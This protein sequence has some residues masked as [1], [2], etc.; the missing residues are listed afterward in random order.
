[1][2]IFTFLWKRPNF[3][4][5]FQVW[6]NLLPLILLIGHLTWAALCNVQ[7]EA[8]GVDHGHRTCFAC[9][10]MSPSN[11]HLPWNEMAVGWCCASPYRFKVIWRRIQD[12]RNDLVFQRSRGNACWKQL[13][14]C[15][16]ILTAQLQD[17]EQVN[18]DWPITFALSKKCSSFLK[19]RWHGQKK[20]HLL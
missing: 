9:P 16:K 10:A 18:Q 5:R 2:N 15:L 20:W 7:L 13:S 14:G 6:E 3:I 8:A 1:M 19:H 12:E 4:K 11:R 17:S